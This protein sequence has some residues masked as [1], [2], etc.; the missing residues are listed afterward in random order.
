MAD[1]H[2][3]ALVRTPIQTG[4]AV[5]AIVPQNFDDAWRIAGALAAAGMGPKDIDT[6]E[7]VLAVMMAG[8]EIGMPPFQ[9]L[10]SF[11]IIN[12]RPAL[13]GDGMMGVVRK[14]GVRVEERTEGL[15]ADGTFVAYCKVTRPDTGEVIER[16]FS[17]VDA[18]RAGL[19]QTEAK[20]RRK[21][22]K[23][24]EFYEATN[25]SP[26]FKYPQR[27]IPM[28][29]R[30]WALRDGCA[31]M[32]RGM[33]MAEEVQD[34]PPEDVRVID[35]SGDADQRPEED[36]D[37]RIGKYGVIGGQAGKDAFDYLAQRMSESEDADALERVQ[38]EA[39]NANLSANRTFALSEHYE[40]CK[41]ALEDGRE[42]PPAPK[43]AKEAPPSPFEALKAEGEAVASID[44][45]NAFNSNMK[46]DL[47]RCTAEEREALKPIHAA[48]KAR[49]A[50]PNPAGLAGKDEG[51]VA[52]GESS[53]A[54][55]PGGSDSPAPSSPEFEK[56]K[57]ECLAILAVKGER[58]QRSAWTAFTALI[59]DAKT[60]AALSDAERAE[61]S[62]IN[63]NVGKEIGA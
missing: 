56:L 46:R 27:M 48:A 63:D 49:A 47:G 53:G 19:W 35:Y 5:A 13:W 50:K 57:Q 45:F 31:D 10:Q 37:P 33:K 3:N 9:S 8:A 4:G 12:G 60:V 58:R 44:A 24:G 36:R 40:A 32:L 61:L 16:S 54:G 39:E 29:A 28:R 2:Q 17:V 14:H 20:V 41:E 59:A 21:N 42:P 15:I 23:T 62:T 22:F 52:A 11:A 1:G 18:K 6:Q 7:K 51:A 25:D 26:W 43:F 38:S 55:Q 30:S 34:Y